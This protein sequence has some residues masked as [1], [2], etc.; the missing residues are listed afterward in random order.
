[1]CLNVNFGIIF[2]KDYMLSMHKESMSIKNV[3]P[4]FT[5]FEGKGLTGLANLGN[6]CF[7]NSALACLSHTYELNKFLGKEEYKKNLNNKPESLILCEWDNLR[8]LIW[9][10]NCTISP[11]GFVGAIQ[12]VARIKDRVIFTG[13]AQ[14]DLTEFLQFVAECFHNSICR[15]V[16]MTIQ[17]SALTDTDKLAKTCYNMMRKM[18]K[19]EYSEFLN[20]FFG[21]HVSKINSLESDYS[22]ITPEPFFNLT[23]PLAKEGTLEKCIELYTKIEQLDGD[24]CIYNEKTDKKERAEK[25]I[26]FW[27]LP[28]VLV[29]TL[30][31]F[32]NNGRKD[33][34]AIDFPLENLDFTNYI[35]GYD[36][37]SYKYDLY[38]ICNHSGGVA[39]GH[40][41]SFVKNANN[42]WYHF[43][44]TNCNEINLGALKT[45]KAY[46]FFYRKQKK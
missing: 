24:N 28:E 26:A 36:R 21:I 19:K 22:N 12:K 41:T 43:N 18:Y 23:V 7:M 11:G 14:N 27:S 31:R 5:E 17:G 35:V 39:G 45:P 30:K 15:E 37:N 32:G 40:Y 29:I 4:E 10:E 42:K 25:Q 16:E 3:N 6:T 8:K 9:S 33:Q 13:F 46:C 34:R 1:M 20:L 38:G 44:D 2:I